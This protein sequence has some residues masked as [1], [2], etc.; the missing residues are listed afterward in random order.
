MNNVVLIATLVDT[1]GLTNA[2]VGPT[3]TFRGYGPPVR[4]RKVEETRP[5]RGFVVRQKFPDVAHL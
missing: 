2:L 5:H 4:V 1:L 3:K